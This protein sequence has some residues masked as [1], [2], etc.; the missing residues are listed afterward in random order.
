MI[1]CTKYEDVP[2]N[3]HR[4]IFSNTLPVMS[5]LKGCSQIA[6]LESVCVLRDHSCQQ[7]LKPL[8]GQHPD[9]CL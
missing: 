5:Q 1:P 2:V 8:Q 6:K 9:E 7:H 3:P 4:C